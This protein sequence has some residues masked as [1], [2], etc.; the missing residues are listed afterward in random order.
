MAAS[1]WQPYHY[2][3]VR[4]PAATPR[5]LGIAPFAA[6]LVILL[7]AA[8]IVVSVSALLFS[9]K[10]SAT[11]CTQRC[12]PPQVSPI[13]SPR[14]YHSSGLGFDVSYPDSWT[15]S[16]S[17]A[18]S[19]VFQTA[20][21]LFVVRGRAAGQADAQLVQSTVNGLP[22]SEWHSVQ[23]VAPIRGA[24]VGYQD[25]TGTIYSANF[26]PNGGQAIKTRLAVLAATKTNLSLV[27]MGIDPYSSHT[28]SGIP[29]DQSFDHVLSLVR[30]PG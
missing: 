12:A 20:L 27:V 7:V 4:P 9:A 19:V 23:P 14:T 16:Q 11:G 13:P 17:D 25:G 30:W 5:H 15:V 18:Q 22:A 1:S 28:H 10:P 8:V 6:L 29:E 24:H 2:P 26:T 3:T 21:G